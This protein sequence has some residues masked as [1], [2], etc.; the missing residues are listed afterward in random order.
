[1]GAQVSPSSLDT[2]E[3]VLSLAKTVLVGQQ[4]GFQDVNGIRIICKYSEPN[5]FDA[6][7]LEVPPADYRSVF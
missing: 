1:M 5:G 2:V 7:L 4:N 6:Y 3:D